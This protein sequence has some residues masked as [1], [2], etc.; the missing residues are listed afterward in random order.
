MDLEPRSYLRHTWPPVAPPPTRSLLG[1]SAS[2]CLG[3]PASPALTRWEEASKNLMIRGLLLP[4][5]GSDSRS[6]PPIHHPPRTMTIATLLIL[7]CCSPWRR[8]EVRG[9]QL[10]RPAS[11]S[12]AWR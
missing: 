6:P 1:G 7:C 4:I 3:T 11:P 12:A 5:Q 10:A 8:G 9:G 2:T